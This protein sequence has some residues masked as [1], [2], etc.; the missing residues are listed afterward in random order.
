MCVTVLIC[1]IYMIPQ[2]R[3]C[4]SND[5]KDTHTE[6]LFAC[7]QE[8]WRQFPVPNFQSHFFSPSYDPFCRLP[9][10][11]SW[12]LGKLCCLLQLVSKG[13]APTVAFQAFVPLLQTLDA[14]SPMEQP[15]LLGIILRLANDDDASFCAQAAAA[16]CE[17][18][19]SCRDPVC[20]LVLSDTLRCA[21]L[22]HSKVRLPHSIYLISTELTWAP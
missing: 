20:A 6:A 22:Q 10:S 9:L 18:A 16:A 5:W 17:L 3:P 12:T 21:V 19:C 1:A 14:F 8:L 2:H 11:C 15:P 13:V 4:A 7:E